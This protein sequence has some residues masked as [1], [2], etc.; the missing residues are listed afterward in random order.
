MKLNTLR[1]YDFVNSKFYILLITR[2]LLVVL[3]IKLGIPKL[4]NFEQ[5]IQYMQSLNIPFSTLAA[6]IAVVMEVVAPIFILIGYYTR[7]IAIIFAF[8]TIG[9]AILGHAYWQVPSELVQSN[10]INFYKNIS[11]AAGFFLLSLTGPGR[12]SLD[13]K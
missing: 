12:Y 3:F 1:Y 9:S 5:T 11:I 4:I 13:K 6:F 10:M 8:Y 7:P 2:V